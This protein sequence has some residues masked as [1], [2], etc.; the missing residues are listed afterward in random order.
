V[1]SA[2][3]P[4]LRVP[5]PGLKWT[6]RLS[7]LAEWHKTT[8]PGVFIAGDVQDHRYRQAVTR[9]DPDGMAALD[10]ERFLEEH[11]EEVLS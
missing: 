10:A 1:A 3:I 6:Q 11:N 9:R 2:T 7:N 8:I 5:R 4:T